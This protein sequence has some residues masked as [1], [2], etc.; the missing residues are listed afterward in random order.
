MPSIVIPPMTSTG[1]MKEGSKLS[2]LDK[3]FYKVCVI[4]RMW[5]VQAR[6]EESLMVGTIDATDHNMQAIPF[7]Y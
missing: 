4:T 7:N 5:W 2:V 3:E 6:G 1:H